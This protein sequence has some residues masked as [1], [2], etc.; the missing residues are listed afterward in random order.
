MIRDRASQSH[1]HTFLL[2]V[3]IIAGIAT[4]ISIIWA[5]YF[6][7]P[8][9]HFDEFYYYSLAQNI[10][11]GNYDDGYVIRGPVYPLFLAG[12]F[13]V[14][15]E[16]FL[17]V[18]IIQ[19]VIRGLVVMIAAYMGRKYMSGGAGVA[20]GLLIAFY[21]SLII[22]CM[23]FLTEA[24]YVPL[25]LASVYFLDRSGQSETYADAFRAGIA[26][27]V[28]SLVRSTS[29]FLTLLLGV[30]FALGKSRSGR[31]SKTSL[32]RAALLV[33]AMFIAISP[34]TV[35]NAV[36]HRGFIP[37]ANDTPYNLWLI[38]SGLHMTTAAGEW[39]MWG[40]HPE[41]QR[42]AYSRWLA[43]LKQ[44]PAFHLK[45]L[46]TVLPTMFAPDWESRA[47]SLSTAY[48]SGEPREIHALKKVIYVWHPVSFWLIFAGGLGGLF[49]AEKNRKRRN[50]VL[51]IVA[52]FI[53]VHGMTLA[54]TR[55]MVP[56]SC[57][58]AIYAGGLIATALQ[59]WGPAGRTRR[60]G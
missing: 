8:Q 45:R 33:L 32:A 23:A 51:I 20:A 39:R 30:W 2:R 4:A 22:S 15:G 59:R 17:P 29:F 7:P 53:L 57:L 18:L 28:A 24:V 10:V 56:L 36:V 38:T 3:I 31:L 14:F 43:H 52:Y 26:S 42:E 16:G 41:R 50:L 6:R 13:K 58:L 60:P 47:Q 46:G 49:L 44:D 35:R 5:V 34:W 54:R 40:T 9:V 11:G 19:A 25:F 37:L 27:G 1:R 55:Y 48:T 12:A 21:P